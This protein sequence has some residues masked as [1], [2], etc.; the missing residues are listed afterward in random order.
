MHICVNVGMPLMHIV[1]H[2]LKRGG[3]WFELLSLVR[4]ELTSLQIPESV[5]CT[6]IVRQG[7]LFKHQP[8]DK[9]YLKS[10]SLLGDVHLHILHKNDIIYLSRDTGFP[11]MW[12]KMTFSLYTISKTI[13]LCD[14]N[15]SN[16]ISICWMLPLI[17]APR[18]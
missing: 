17:I 10:N 7:L 15:A 3:S 16:I 6:V 14:S 8:L 5:Q 4:L 9:P 12:S 1:Y 13:V 18:N 2:L 11:T